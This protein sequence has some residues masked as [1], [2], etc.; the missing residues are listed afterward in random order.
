MHTRQA[1]C[2]SYANKAFS[3]SQCNLLHKYK[4]LKDKVC[5]VT[6]QQQQKTVSFLKCP[7]IQSIPLTNFF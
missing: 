5:I 1:S 2:I 7:N 6:T 3:L 4:I